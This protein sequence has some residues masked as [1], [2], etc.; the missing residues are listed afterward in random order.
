MDEQATASGGLV[1]ISIDLELDIEQRD[2]FGEQ[3][4]D[5]ARSRLIA[6]TARHGVP[7]TWAV[8]DPL[9]SA[10]S[11]QVLAAGV[12]HE[13]A[14]LG[15]RTWIGYGAG[16]TRLDRELARR[17]DGPRQVGIPVTTLALRNVEQVLDLDLLLGHGITA[18]RHPAVD[19]AS[20]ARK[21]APPPIRFGIWQAPAAWSIPPRAGWWISSGWRIRRETQRAIAR[22]SQ[23][24]LAIDAPR[25][26]AACADG[27]AAIERTLAY[28]SAQRALGRVTVATLGQLARQSLKG[29]SAVPTRSVLRS[30][31]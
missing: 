7:A 26:I 5:E 2:Q 8:A 29:R 20:L 18:V 30:A 1:V 12:G 13:L 25:L 24:H 6:M 27:L 31:A 4:L 14:V 19:S 17:F 22:G 23:L 28:V 9:H 16:R 10:A 11:D 21:L 3:Q 15:D